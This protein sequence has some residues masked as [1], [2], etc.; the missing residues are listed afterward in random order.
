[1][2]SEIYMTVVTYEFD[3]DADSS[4]VLSSDWVRL[5][6][7]S[8]GTCYRNVHD[9]SV[10]MKVGSISENGPYLTFLEHV[11]NLG[12]NNKYLPVIYHV[13]FIYNDEYRNSG[14]FLVEMERLHHMK[15]CDEDKVKSKIYNKIYNAIELNDHK[16]ISTMNA[17]LKAACLLVKHSFN[18]SENKGHDPGVD[19]HSYNVMMRKGTCVI[20]DPLS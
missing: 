6:S 20:T 14:V 3:A 11:V 5:D 17:E 13:H 1:M 16:A 19:L 15:D 8:F 2:P 12:E 4:D 7:G 9:D 18:V 10:I